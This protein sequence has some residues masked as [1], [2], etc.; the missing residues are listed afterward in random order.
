MQNRKMYRYIFNLRELK[1][2]GV[3]KLK[4]WVGNGMQKKNSFF[5]E[6]LSGVHVLPLSF[7]LSRYVAPLGA[8]WSEDEHVSVSE[9]GNCGIEFGTWRIQN[10]ISVKWCS[11]SP[12]FEE[13]FSCVIK[14]L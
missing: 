6:V 2:M 8:I 4:Q 1:V 3:I 5:C 13:Q 10:Q 12:C 11:P 7:S 9:Q 14:K